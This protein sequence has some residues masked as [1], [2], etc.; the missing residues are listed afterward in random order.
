MV[1]PQQGVI[2]VRMK[3]AC[4]LQTNITPTIPVVLTWRVVVISVCLIVSKVQYFP[5]PM[6]KN[7]LQ[8]IDI[9]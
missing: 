7:M 3:R 9:M 4:I 2:I 8:V 1:D 5:L 6:S